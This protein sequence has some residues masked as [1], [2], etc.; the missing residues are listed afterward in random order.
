MEVSRTS[1]QNDVEELRRGQKPH[2]TK[3]LVARVGNILG[4]ITA[5]PA[6]KFN[7][8]PMPGDSGEGNRDSGLIVISIPG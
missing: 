7:F 2:K 5:I 3:R 4:T 8:K 6:D 1:S